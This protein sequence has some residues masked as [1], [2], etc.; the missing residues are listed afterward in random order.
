LIS[1]SGDGVPQK[2]TKVPEKILSRAALWAVVISSFLS[3]LVQGVPAPEAA[4]YTGQCQA[5]LQGSSEY[6]EE[7]TYTVRW[8]LIPA[9]KAT[10]SL[11]PL[12]DQEGPARYRIE[13]RARSNRFIDV[14][15]RVRDSAV[16]LAAGGFERS[17]YFSK[18]QREGNFSREEVLE[19]D[20]WDGVG[21]LFRNGHFTNSI[22]LPESVQDPISGL[23]R[24]RIMETQPGVEARMYA[25]DGRRV[26]LARAPIL[27]REKVKTAAGEFECLKLELFP[28]TLE[29]PFKVKKHGRIF[30][31]FTD[32]ECRLP[33]KM[34]TEIFIGSVE[35]TLDEVKYRPNVELP[36]RD[37]RPE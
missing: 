12:T 8:G 7:L 33:V 10:L 37:D 29:G 5:L 34:S 9:G 22:R 11:T 1:A 19:Y 21:L 13:S 14:F 6:L 20:S 3:I 30:M 26:V 15:F 35:T 2:V 23:Y 27:K 31:W 32:D 4:A 36:W 24:F 18:S 16:S 17:L 28:K 25:T